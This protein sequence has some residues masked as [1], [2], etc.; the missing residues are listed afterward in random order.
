VAVSGIGVGTLVGPPLANRLI[1]EYGWRSTYRIFAVIAVV[2]LL[3]AATLVAR[4]PIA[5]GQAPLDLGLVV[6]RPMFR[7]LYVSGLLM[8]IALFVPFVFLTPYAEDHGVSAG[9][10]AS[11]LSFLGVGSLAGR[12]ALAPLA[13]RLGVLVLYQLCFVVLGAS[14]LI[15]LVGG[16]RFVVLATFAVVL[17]LSYGGYVALSPAATAELFGLSG[18][19]AVLGALYTAGGIGGLIGPPVAGA[20]IDAAGGY[21]IA[22]TGAF[23]L[24]VVAVVILHRAIRTAGS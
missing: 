5:V 24:S 17:G 19:G 16:G 12:L 8:T 14:F 20:V 6:R 18:L 10:A 22:I 1:E 21:S 7:S 13:G 9:A 15:W 4:A 11:L 2:G 23:G 3:I